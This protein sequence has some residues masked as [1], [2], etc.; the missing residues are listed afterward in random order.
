M[1]TAMS[2]HNKWSQIKNKKE[3]T[4]KKKSTLF[5]K[6]LAAIAIAAKADP[7]PES[8]PRLRSLVEKARGVNVPNENISRAISRAS[9]DKNLKEFTIEAIGPEKSAIIIETITDNSNRTVQEI[10]Q[11]LLAGGAKMTDPGGARWAF[12]LSADHRWL[13]KIPQPLT[14]AGQAALA[15][16]IET[17]EENAD[18]QRVI[19]NTEP[20]TND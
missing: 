10:R 3:A 16:L 7:S 20:T 1:M 8:N 5:S 15:K 4:D 12:T 2:G 9:E 13:A 11:I 6:V 14:P 19:T 18:V 17:L